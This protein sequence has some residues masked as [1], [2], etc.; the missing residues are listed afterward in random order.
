MIIDMEKIKEFFK[1]Y[2][3]VQ[4]VLLMIGISLVMLFLISLFI[5]CYSR[6]GKEFEMPQFSATDSTPGMTVKEAMENNELD[7]EFVVIDS[8]V[9]NA[10]VKPGII[11]TQDPK[12]G[13]MVKKGRTVYVSV[14]AAHAEDVIMP[15]LVQLS[16]RHAVSQIESKGLKVG[17]I[18]FVDDPYQNNVKEQR[19]GGRTVYPG[20]KVAPGTAID[21]VVGNGNNGGS[22]QVPFV[23]GKT[24]SQA[25]NDIYGR[26]LNVGREHWDGVRDRDR[27]RVYRQEPDYTGVNTY[28]FGTSVELWYKE[29]TE[30]EA[31]RMRA[32]FKVDSS[33]I[34]REE[35]ELLPE[36]IDQYDYE[37][38]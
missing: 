9:Y 12:A 15:E 6:H 3:W 37:E 27:A 19:V 14:S 30:E 25:H 22:V 20:D 28:P 35:P 24:A 34:I 33:K 7:L 38:W 5:K 8:S 17:T 36:I 10:D 18:T 4:H 11:L 16:L 26:S 2:P 31:E 23:I 13:S 21:L 1:K 29:A 32:D